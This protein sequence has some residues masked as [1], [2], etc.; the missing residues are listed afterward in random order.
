[1]AKAVEWL[2]IQKAAGQQTFSYYERKLM[3]VHAIRFC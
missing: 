1:M 3:W 2:K